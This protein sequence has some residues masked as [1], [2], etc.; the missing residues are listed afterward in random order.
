M[1]S[2]LFL[3]LS[4]LTTF[5]NATTCN[6]GWESPS[7]GRGTCSHHGG[8][9]GGSIGYYPA[10]SPNEPAPTT[11]IPVTQARLPSIP[12]DTTAPALRLPKWPYEKSVNTKGRVTH[13]LYSPDAAKR[14]GVWGMMSYRCIYFEADRYEEM[15]TILLP[16]NIDYIGKE[17][18]IASVDDDS[19]VRVYAVKG[20]MS[21]FLPSWAAISNTDGELLLR[22]G[23]DGIA[24]NSRLDDELF[25][26]QGDLQ[27]IEQSEHIYVFAMNADGSYDSYEIPMDGFSASMDMLRTTSCTGR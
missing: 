11:P 8:I 6:D 21:K 16:S 22:K 26:T 27:T 9:A 4:F 12:P 7:S 5:A 14:S 2:T 18:R 24:F 23:T 20:N 10:Y 25:L 1:L 15:I 13:T 19:V 3:T 17:S